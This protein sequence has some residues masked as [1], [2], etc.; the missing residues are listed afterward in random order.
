ML[1][2][3]VEQNPGYDLVTNGP[4]KA[5]NPQG[6]LADPNDWLNK[7]VPTYEV[8]NV[9][10]VEGLTRLMRAFDRKYDASRIRGGNDTPPLVF[11]VSLSPGT[12]RDVLDAI[13]QILHGAWVVSYGGT[14]ASYDVLAHGAAYWVVDPFPTGGP[15]I[16]LGGRGWEVWTAFSEFR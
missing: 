7:A 5:I 11:S 3:V 16:T 15:R 12:V 13:A 9:T 2:Y 10:V 8:R 1:G 6:A 4:V 14:T